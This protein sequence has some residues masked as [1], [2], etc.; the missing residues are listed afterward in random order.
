MKRAATIKDVA[1]HAGVSLGTVSNYLNAT[2]PISPTT[3]QRIEDAIAALRFVPNNSV[4]T[5]H[6]RRSKVIGFVVPDALNPFFTELAR[7]VEDVA[8]SQDCVV[9]FC[10][11]AGEEARERAYL[12]QLAEMRVTGVVL[13][14]VN[15]ERISIE[16][17]QAVDAQVV[18][19]GDDKPGVSASS[20][21]AD[22]LRGGYLAMNHLL[23]IGRRNVLFAGGPAGGLVLDMRVR[24]A[25]QAI[26]DSG[27]SAKLRRVDAVGRLVS[28][29]AALVDRVL[30]QD[31]PP[32]AVICGND[33]IAL[34]IL[35]ALLRRGAK[36]PDDVAI[37]G[38]DDIEAASQAVIPLT[39]VR[40]P[41]E[42]LGR[43]AAELLFSSDTQ[44]RKPERIIFEPELVVRES[45]VRSPSSPHIK[46]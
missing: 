31:D 36:V 17:L 45:T 3:T 43:T 35:N 46:I 24:G 6:G 7:H 2:K 21:T 37:V 9:V 26:A 10:D 30:D 20:V 33:M 44:R 23:S 22:D 27:T 34:S 5:L 19:L 12:R 29:R 8:R 32:D 13:T 40:Q 16:D 11:T 42:R 14:S 39:T 28:H 25:H 4:R 1:A 41:I 15:H 38:H 18:L